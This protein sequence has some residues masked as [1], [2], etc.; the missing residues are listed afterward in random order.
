MNTDMEHCRYEA[1]GSEAQESR[2]LLSSPEPAQNFTNP[3]PSELK[4][5]TQHALPRGTGREDLEPHEMHGSGSFAPF[6]L[7][8]TTEEPLLIEQSATASTPAEA[9]NGMRRSESGRKSSIRSHRSGRPAI[10]HRHSTLDSLP[11]LPTERGTPE[12][13]EGDFFSPISPMGEKAEW[14]GKSGS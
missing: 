5:D 14:I 10:H 8:G 9:D 4:G 13:R 1:P 7:P 2:T 11:S 6:E 3:L 12:P